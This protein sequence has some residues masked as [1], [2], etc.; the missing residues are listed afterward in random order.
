VPD[1][2]RR[3]LYRVAALLET[4]DEL[5]NTYQQEVDEVLR[6]YQEAASR[7]D[8]REL[9]LDLES[10][11]ATAHRFRWSDIA[12]AAEAAGWRPESD[13][14]PSFADMSVGEQRELYG[15]LLDLAAEAGLRRIGELVSYGENIHSHEDLLRTIAQRG[16][17]ARYRPYAVPPDVL[18][19]LLVATHPDRFR[20]RTSEIDAV[21]IDPLWMAA[22][23]ELGAVTG[24]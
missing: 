20:R 8:W 6:S 4:G 7:S 13:D 9:P 24:P 22:L 11:L 5:F 18:S 16:E 1:A 19:L 12:G 14:P 2:V 17:R 23:G 15:R 21:F 3:R 10:L